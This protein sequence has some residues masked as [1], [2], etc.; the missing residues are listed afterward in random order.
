MAPL[1]LVFHALCDKTQPGDRL[2]VVGNVKQLGKWIPHQG[3]ELFTNAKSF[4]LWTSLLEGEVVTGELIEMH[5]PHRLEFKFVILRGKEEIWEPIQQNRIVDLPPIGSVTVSGTWGRDDTSQGQWG[6]S[7]KGNQFSLSASWMG[8]EVKQL[9]TRSQSL[10]HNSDAGEEPPSL[11]VKTIAEGN[12]TAGSW[13]KKLELI[14][15]VLGDLDLNRSNFEKNASTAIETLAACSVFLSLV[16]AGTIHCSEDGGHHRP[17]HHSTISRDLFLKLEA[18]GADLVAI[19]NV[20]AHILRL[21]IRKIHPT[22]PS[23]SD[24]FTSAQPLTRIRDIAHRNDIPRELK[25]ELKHKIQNKLHRCAGPEDLVETEKMMARFNANPGNYPPDFVS[26]FQRFHTELREF[27][28]AT[29]LSDRLAAIGKREQGE[30][31]VTTSLINQY[32]TSK[33]HTDS[34]SAALPQ[35]ITTLKL[36][37]ELR[38]VLVQEVLTRVNLLGDGERSAAAGPHL[39]QMRLAEIGLEESAFVLASRIEAHLTHSGEGGSWVEALEALVQVVKHV[40]FSACVDKN[41]CSAIVKELSMLTH[42]EPFSAIDIHLRRAMVSRTRRLSETYA[43]LVLEVFPRTALAL[44]KLVGAAPHSVK[45]FAEA[46]IR[47]NLM[48]QISKITSHLLSRCRHAL[49]DHSITPIVPGRAVGRLVRCNDLTTAVRGVE[50]VTKGGEGGGE[51]GREGDSVSDEPKVLFAMSA[52]GDEEVGGLGFKGVSGV[53]LGHDIP[54]LSHLAVRARQEGLVLACCQDEVDLAQVTSLMNH[55]V[56]LDTAHPENRTLTKA[57]DSSEVSDSNDKPNELNEVL[58]EELKRCFVT[59]S[60]RADSLNRLISPSP[61]PTTSGTAATRHTG[62]E[63]DLA[64]LD[65]IDHPVLVGPGEVTKANSGSKAMRCA[66]LQQISEQ[67]GCGFRCPRVMTFPFGTFESLLKRAGSY[68]EYEAQCKALDLA[69]PQSESTDKK[70]KEVQTLLR[71]LT[72]L[73]AHIEAAQEFASSSPMGVD[74]RLMVRSSANAED[75][76][77]YSAAGLYDSVANVNVLAERGDVFIQA[78]GLVWASLFSRRAVVSRKM[79]SIPQTGASMAIL[80]QESLNPSHCFILH[81]VNPFLP[82][83]SSHTE[84]KEV[85]A[86]DPRNEVFIE[87]AVGLGETLASGSMRGSPHRF[88]VNKVT[89]AFEVVS[90]ANYSKCLIPV[91]QMSNVFEAGSDVKQSLTSAAIESKTV[92]YTQDRLVVDSAYRE[93]VVKRLSQVAVAIETQ[94]KCPQD[95]EGAIV[96]DVIYIVQTRPQHGVT[97]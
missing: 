4:P 55:L 6:V 17:S 2:C 36:I 16:S 49:N 19:D 64:F 54:H 5:V 87:L 43:E 62:T 70:C 21:L 84:V 57:S 69:D 22:L 61:S 38:G 88:K 35:M 52:S 65:D 30:G 26:E 47:G 3:T 46:D 32:I 85:S 66:M 71:G 89:K 74:C 73:P 12:K 37:T 92:D 81:T 80:L 93:D 51:N 1:S 86:E 91:E 41:E 34:P 33:R 39:Q 68:A 63:D 40:Q 79:A 83:L 75:L 18:M 97:K 82:P 72:L 8:D 45:M 95:V 23:F 60:F 29:A 59:A 13:R 25:E 76:E 28:N 11:T 56:I 90:F 27:F 53:I 58:N 9:V 44:G 67:P 42:S 96:D 77:N 50:G 10:L 24:E 7:E 94:M 78:V 14:R 48:F 15:S 31:G 20:K